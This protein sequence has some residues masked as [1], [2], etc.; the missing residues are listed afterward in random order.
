[1]MNRTDVHRLF[2]SQFGVADL[3][4]L[5][6]LGLAPS[7]VLRTQRRGAITPVLPGVFQVAGGELS[8]RGKAMAAQLHGGYRRVLSG[9]PAGAL[10]GARGKPMTRVQITVGGKV[11][12]HPAPWM[13]GRPSVL[14]RQSHVVTRDDGLRL[15]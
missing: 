9:T 14:D 5:V 2:H 8:F 12:T 13:R 10:G 1:M 4:Q 7:T 3:A 11:R 6:S 15:A